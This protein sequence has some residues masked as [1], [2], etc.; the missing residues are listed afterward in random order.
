[1]KSHLQKLILLVIMVLLVPGAIFAGTTGKIVGRVTDAKSG[2]ALPGVNI[3]IEGTSTGAASDLDGNF[4]ILHVHP[5]TYTVRASMIGYQSVRFQ[6]ARVSIDLTTTINFSLEEEVLDLG[7]E[8]TVIAER[9]MVTK[10]LTATTAV[11]DADQIA[12]LPVTEISEA[13]ELQAG[14]VKDA[15]GGLHVRGGRSGEVSYWIDGIPVTDVYDGGSVVEVNKDMVQELQV[16]SGAFNAEYGQAMSGIVNIATKSGSNEFG[17]SFTTYLGDHLS[18]NSDVFM[19]IDDFNP[20]S[21]YNFDGSLHGAIIKDKLFYYANARYINFDGWL[22]GQ[23]RFNPNTI[24]AS[25]GGFPRDYLQDVAPEYLEDAKLLDDNSYEILYLLGTN[26]DL[27]ELITRT[28]LSGDSY[29]GGN[30][31]EDSIQAQLARLRKNHQ[32]GRGDGEYVPMN[33]NRKVYGQGK[34]IYKPFAPVTLSYN[35]IYDDVDYRDFERDY[36]YNPD[37]ATKK[38][39]NGQTHILQLTHMLTSRTFYTLGFSYFSKGYESYV[40]EDIYDSRYIHPNVASLQIPYS[41]KTGGTNNQRFERSTDTYLGKFDITSQV[42]NTHQLKFGFEWRQHDVY[43]RD[44]TLRPIIEQSAIDLVWDSPYIQ[45][46]VMPDSTIHASQYRHKPLE[47]SGYIQ[48][49][50]EFKNL[51]VNFGVRFDYFDP[52]G[53]VLKDESDPSIYNPIRPEN[54]YYDYGTDG[55][56]NTYDA[57]GTEGNGL[58]DQGEAA[59]S[60]TER[61]RYWYKDASSNFKVSPRIGVSFPITERGIIHFSYGHFFQIP[62][63]ERLYQNPDF[64]L[65]S[66]TGNQGVIG[67]AALEPEQTINGEIGLQQQLTKD[68]ALDVTGYFRDIRN[69]AGTNAEEIFVYGGFAKYSKIVNSDFGFVRGIILSLTQRFS[70]GLS[71]SVDYTLQQAK[72]TN[73]NPEQARNALAGGALPE[74]QLTSLEW[75]QRHTLNATVSY[76]APTWGGSILAQYGSGL[77]YTPR[78][79]QDIST[80]LSNS[81]LKPGNFNVDLKL[82]RDFKVSFG[83]VSVFTRIFNLF[84]RLNEVNVYTDTGKAG[85]T[86]DLEVAEKTNPDEL[87]NT[88]NDWF[89]NPTHYSEPR[90]IE[91]GVSINF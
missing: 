68:I 84:D 3:I 9:P 29:L 86:Q 16:V 6:N 43:Q 2:T 30:V 57:D 32:N 75:D 22:Y 82:Y 4:L 35:Y 50:M 89:T 72:G 11:V 20:A 48:D 87:V 41:Y 17:G 47:L 61:Q 7:A 53:V 19:H 81:Q 13:V 34:L 76:A 45:T 14:L 25:I 69:L 74:I 62:R 63:F 12:A 83:T 44:I 90:R 54:R 5:G 88:L 91:A 23:R 36:K 39:R 40:Y 78:A 28:L 21:I 37:G 26:A 67:N 73:S 8:I 80:L 59:V 15:A 64:E 49:K 27:D 1:M 42:T 65:G 56:P 10:D 52:D 38:F 46:R 55:L 31:S 18:Q 79:S 77:P 58:K 24:A 85:F 71:A 66:G 60:L 70:G 51:I 33:G